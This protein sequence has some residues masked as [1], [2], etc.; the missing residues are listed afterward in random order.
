[1]KELIYTLDDLREIT[2]GNINKRLGI[3]VVGSHIHNG[4]LKCLETVRNQSDFILGVYLSNWY[5][6]VKKVYGVA[7]QKDKEFQFETLDEVYKL[8]DSTLVLSGNYLPY[9]SSDGRIADLLYSEL[10]NYCLPIWMTEDDQYM[11]SLRSGQ[12]FVYVIRSVYPF[13]EIAGS[14][15]DPWK[16]Y[17]ARWCLENQK[18]TYTMIAPETDEYGNC[19]S[20]HFIEWQRNQNFRIT[21]PILEKG[22]TSIEDV[23]CY[24]QSKGILGITA[25][26]LHYNDEYK[27][28]YS[29]LRYGEF[30]WNEARYVG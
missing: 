6:M 16:P 19:Y 8:S 24:L 1:M 29:R 18:F 28:L 15:K 9:G 2:A 7:L 26:T 5:A 25:E 13:T 4:H 14:I 21:F 11:G 10:P 23:N 22:M 20:S 12:M 17:T 3:W 30:F 27:Y